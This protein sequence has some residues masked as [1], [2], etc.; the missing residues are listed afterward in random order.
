LEQRVAVG[1]PFSEAVP[2]TGAALNNVLTP[3]DRGAADNRA[4]AAVQLALPVPAI[5]QS[6]DTHSRSY[7]AGLHR[8]IRVCKKALLYGDFSKLL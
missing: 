7:T 8:Q 6:A 5:V 3:T 4:F 2:A 1:L